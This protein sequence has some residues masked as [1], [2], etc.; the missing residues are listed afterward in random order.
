[1]FYDL[2][3]INFKALSLEKSFLIISTKFKKH[4]N[5][6][7]LLV[8]KIIVSALFVSVLLLF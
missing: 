8:S 3:G 1:M 5:Y 4:L 6:G 7:N 2:G